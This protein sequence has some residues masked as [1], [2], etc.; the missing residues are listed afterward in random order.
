LITFLLKAVAISLSGVLAPGPMTAATIAA[1]TRSRNAGALI[2]LGH[3][4]IEFPLMIVIIAGAGKLFESDGIKMGIGLA[5]GVVLLLMGIQLLTAARKAES[6]PE[7][8][9]GRHPFW[10]GIVLTGAN[11]YF[12]IWWATIGLALATQAVELGMLAFVLFAVVHWLCDLVWLEALSLA[13]FKGTELL[14]DSIQKIVLIM[15]GAML[16]G[17]GCKFLYDAGKDLWL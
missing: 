12:L 16:L 11:P 9:G 6:L 8:S 2:A 7:A 17:F 4:A 5:G 13:S 10:T 1:G 15:C 14:G 3:A